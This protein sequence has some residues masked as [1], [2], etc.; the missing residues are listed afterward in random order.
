M[1]VISRK[2]G[3]GVRIGDD[4]LVQ[5]LQMG[6][7]E[8]GDLR[9]IVSVTTPEGTIV[10]RGDELPAELHRHLQHGGPPHSPSEP[11]VPPATDA[12]SDPRPSSEGLS[13][14]RDLPVWK[15]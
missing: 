13:R 1:V 3:D 2:A 8:R 7:D 6:V 11:P 5:V 12:A 15:L 10:S 14:N 4:V 9:V